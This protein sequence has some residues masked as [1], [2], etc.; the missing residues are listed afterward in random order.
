[1]FYLKTIGIKDFKQIKSINIYDL[2]PSPWIFLTGE[3]G[4]G[5]T[6]FLQALAISLNSV[7]MVIN[8]S[9]S[10]TKTKTMV[11]LHSDVSF[12][13]QPKGAVVERNSNFKFLVCYGASRLETYTESAQTEKAMTSSGLDRLFEARTL[14]GNIEFELIKWKLKADSRSL[15]ETERNIFE[16]KLRF[17]KSIFIDLLDILDVQV[18][19]RKDKVLYVEKDSAGNPLPPINKE[20]LGSGYRALIGIIGDLILRLSKSQPDTTNPSDLHGIVII[21]E[22]E[23]HLHP[24]WQKSLPGILS[25]YFPKVQFI[26]STHSPI[27][28]LG[29]PEHSI[30]L[31]VNRSTEDGI[32]IE[33]LAKLEKDIRY[34]MPNAV[35]T[36]DIFDFSEIESAHSTDINAL[37]TEDSYHDI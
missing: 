19:A 25:K 33:R 2:P 31:K 7:D 24:R 27:P 8:G 21:D 10:A 5:K 18:D 9:M 34:L 26:A 13:I 4:F 35:L 17:T 15:S 1:M 30:F 28:L 37:K 36:S 11:L 23:L 12:G 14:L 6:V 16:A 32:T 22:I 29:A 3:N 20:L